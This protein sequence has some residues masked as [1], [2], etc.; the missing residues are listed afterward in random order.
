MDPKVD[1]YIAKQPS[2]QK[3]ILEELRKLIL[4]T[5]PQ[6]KEEFKLGVP[7]YDDKY[8]LVGL[9][10][11]VNFGFSIKGMTPDEIAQFDGGGKTTKTVQIMSVDQIDESR[12]VKLM[13]M[14]KAPYI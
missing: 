1:A 4:K 12:L 7:V 3:E 2:P 5:F 6:I 9:K 11:H 13:K 8:Y 14:V 10:D